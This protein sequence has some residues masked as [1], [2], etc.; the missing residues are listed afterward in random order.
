ME[1]IDGA[2]DDDVHCSEETGALSGAEA[3]WEVKRREEVGEVQCR[4]G[5]HRR[6][7]WG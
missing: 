7:D 5:I 2:D 3:G 1:R 6:C 4:M